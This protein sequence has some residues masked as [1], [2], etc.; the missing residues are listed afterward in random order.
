MP[1]PMFTPC[2]IA[3]QAVDERRPDMPLYEVLSNVRYEHKVTTKTL[4]PYRVLWART[5]IGLQTDYSGTSIY[6]VE[7]SDFVVARKRS[8]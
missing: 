4:Y 1:K 8:N 2:E 5:W 3:I 6:R 7:L